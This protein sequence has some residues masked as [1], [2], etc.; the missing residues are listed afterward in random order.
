MEKLRLSIP[1]IAEN[2]SKIF[3][4]MAEGIELVAGLIAYYAAVEPHY[5][6]PGSAV[7]AQL[8]EA[9][10]D[11]YSA[12][13]HYLAVA[14]S[15]YRKR[16]FLR[17][18][19]SLL[20][21]AES[22]VDAPLSRIRSEHVKFEQLA[23]AVDVESS[24]RSEAGILSIEKTVAS[25]HND[26]L[27]LAKLSKGIQDKLESFADVSIPRVPF[28]AQRKQEDQADLIRWLSDIPYASHHAQMRKNLVVNSGQWLIESPRF[29]AWRKLSKPASMWLH[30]KIGCG[31]T[32]LMSSI[33][34]HFLEQ[35]DVHG[36]SAARVAYFYCDKSEE[37]RT[38]T[39]EVLRSI[40][41]QLAKSQRDTSLIWPLPEIYSRKKLD[42]ENL[43]ESMP[44]K[45]SSSECLDLINGFSV[46]FNT[47]ILIDGLDECRDVNS[48]L[49]AVLKMLEIG[50]SRVVLSGRD[51][52]NR[53][54]DAYDLTALTHFSASDNE[55]DINCF[56]ASEIDSIIK[57]K[58]LLHGK[59]SSSLRE[60]I[61]DT[62]IA[63]ADGM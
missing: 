42:S 48:L 58:R 3:R 1:K 29:K 45:L 51:E 6:I 52:I 24:R 61:M 19:E 22:E 34:Q 12:I 2:D 39:E 57:H 41:R 10:V 27:D 37:R 44:S 7:I 8:T 5:L 25:A 62:L 14:K 60:K 18:F 49:D 11:V 40:V 38:D 28:Q 43:G 21:T 59:V 9:T 35:L 54:I 31:K 50:K 36:E 33:I 26:I 15:Y 13:L 63:G 55:D 30:G 53:A 23:K 16:T 32:R 17:S 46:E 4:H 47:I 56:I 20:K